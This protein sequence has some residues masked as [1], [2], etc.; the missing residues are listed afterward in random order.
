[1][2]AGMS[3]AATRAALWA[4]ELWRLSQPEV[5]CRDYVLVEVRG[6]SGD[7]Q[8]AVA[9]ALDE[10]VVRERLERGCRCFAARTRSDEVASWLWVST[11]CEWAPPLQQRLYFAPDECYGWGAGTLPQHRRRGLFTSVLRWA[12]WR[13]AQ[14]GCRLMWDGIL[15][16]NLPSQRAHAAAGMRPILRMTAVH[17]PAPTPLRLRAADYA[18]PELVRRARRVVGGPSERRP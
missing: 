13:M 2:S 6:A 12:G 7:D 17:Q 1:M 5:P 3:A 8:L 11:G 4:N 18:D 14:D 16:E 10:S 15:D 9:M